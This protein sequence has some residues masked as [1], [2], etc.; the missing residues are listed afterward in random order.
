ML[1]PDRPGA[2]DKHGDRPERLVTQ[3]VQSVRSSVRLNQLL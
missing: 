2:A 3:E 1:V